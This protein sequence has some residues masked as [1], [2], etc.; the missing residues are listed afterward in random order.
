MYRQPP[1]YGRKAKVSYHVQEGRLNG[2]PSAGPLLA[3]WTPKM[4]VVSHA[5]HERNEE[6]EAH[7]DQ[8]I[9]RPVHTEDKTGNG[10]QA[11]PKHGEHHHKVPGAGP[12]ARHAQRS[13]GSKCCS[14]EG[15]ATGETGTPVPLRLL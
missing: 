11:C 4:K 5:D 2:R 9:R 15:M 14:A 3:L 13:S 1:A 10:D 6:P 12:Y 8:D 7:C